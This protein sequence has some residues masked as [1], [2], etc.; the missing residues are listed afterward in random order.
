MV[1]VACAVLSMSVPASA[2]CQAQPFERALDDAE[3]VWWGTIINADVPSGGP[4]V[5]RL[6]VTVQEVLKGPA[7]P[8]EGQFVYLATCGAAVSRREAR[9]T[10]GSFVNQERLLLVSQTADGLIAAP[11]Q[12]SPDLTPREEYQRAATYLGIVSDQPA[13]GDEEQGSSWWKV[14]L[15]AS[16]SLVLAMLSFLALRKRRRDAAK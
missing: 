10:A 11:D 14:W 5:W 4:G 15:A 12:W 16:V 3:S 1:V 6:T 13:A 2:F 9:R 7:L 8:S